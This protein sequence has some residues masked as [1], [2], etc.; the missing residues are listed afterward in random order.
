MNVR[1]TLYARSE[2]F[3]DVA[4][5]PFNRQSFHQK[6]HSRMYIAVA[7]LMVLQNQLFSQRF[8]IG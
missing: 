1:L 8:Q 6:V 2:F 4:D 7:S 3:R 5:V